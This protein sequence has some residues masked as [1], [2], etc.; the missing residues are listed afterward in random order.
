MKQ[1]A[2][3]QR[4]VSL[5]KEKN[6]TQEELVERSHVSVRTIQRIESGEVVPRL[7]TLKIIA[8]ALSVDFESI[9]Q[10][11]Q[12]QMEENKNSIAVFFN[13]T[14]N[15][16]AGKSALL[17]AAIAGI[18]YLLL[19]II[20]M[21]LD[22]AW[23][24]EAFGHK[25][26]IVYVTI[27]VCLISSYFLF[28]RGF[29]I[30]GYLFENGLLRVVGFMLIIAMIALSVLDIYTLFYLQV[31]PLQNWKNLLFIP[32]GAASMI[33]GVLGL[34]FGTALLKLQDGMGELSKVTGILEIVA[35]V[36]LVTVILFFIGLTI[37]MPATILEIIL[38]FRGYEYL[39]KA[40]STTVS[41]V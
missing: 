17:T 30:L 25:G 21:A 20:K 2:L 23:M 37:L 38:L 29:I 39:S 6:L 33:Y 9:V 1:P 24:S 40:S 31:D 16:D 41:S 15:S 28:V 32:Y 36:F 35:G 26:N 4:L 7:S 8:K 5:R 13:P 14:G 34:V 27:V 22:L 18:I 3:G 19:E 10:T 11:N 12:N